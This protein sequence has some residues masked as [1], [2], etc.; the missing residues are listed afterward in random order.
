MSFV[1]LVYPWMN[2]VDLAR[3]LPRALRELRR[4][5]IGWR[6]RLVIARSLPKV[7]ILE[8]PH[9]Y[10]IS[11][12][13]TPERRLALVSDLTRLNVP[14]KISFATDGLLHFAEK[15]LFKYAGP[16]RRHKIALSNRHLKFGT[17]S[18]LHE[19]LRFG[20]YLSHVRIWEQL[21]YS[22]HSHMVILEDDVLVS[23]EFPNKLAKM[24]KQL[25]HNWEVFYLNSCYTKFGG[26]LVPGIRQVKGALCTYG[27][28]V[29][30]I[31]ANK[32]LRNTARNCDKPVDHMLDQA[33]YSAVVHAYQAEPP[34]IFP[35]KIESTLAYPS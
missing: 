17:R 30:R 29:S 24:L 6:E 5:S 28:A 22:N 13:R 20:C 3:I 8:D 33:I 18:Y 15:D 11:L 27:Y 31:G 26:T 25:P 23:E 35:R 2:G 9:V 34:I 32:I 12:M 21:A 16:R 7:V 19:R 10:I 14:F 4:N 1:C